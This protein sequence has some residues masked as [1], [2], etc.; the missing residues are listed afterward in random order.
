MDQ[1]PTSQEY[2]NLRDEFSRRS[3]AEWFGCSIEELQCAVISVGSR[4]RDVEIH[5]GFYK[6]DDVRVTARSDAL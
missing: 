6:P 4:V 3:W 5:L 2:I 1:S